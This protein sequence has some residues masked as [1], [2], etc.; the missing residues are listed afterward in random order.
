MSDSMCVGFAHASPGTSARLLRGLDPYLVTRSTE[1]DDLYT[2]R[3]A[4][5]NRELSR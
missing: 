4:R 3:L 5:R 1:A 2:A